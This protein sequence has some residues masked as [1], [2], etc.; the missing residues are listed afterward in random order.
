MNILQGRRK[1]FHGGGWGGL[2]KNVGHHGWLAVKK[3]KKALIK[4][5]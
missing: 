1:L 2:S 5:P 3:I 4:T